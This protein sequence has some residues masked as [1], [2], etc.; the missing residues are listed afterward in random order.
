MY[1]LS[2]FDPWVVS[3]VS[4]LNTYPINVNAVCQATVTL[5]IYNNNNYYYY[6]F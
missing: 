2:Q 6:A 1:F 3:L 4:Y 5:E